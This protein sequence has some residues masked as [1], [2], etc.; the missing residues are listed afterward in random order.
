VTWLFQ[1]PK[2]KEIRILSFSGKEKPKLDQKPV[3]KFFSAGEESP[4][5]PWNRI[6][7][8]PCPN[9]GNDVK[10]SMRRI[11]VSVNQLRICSAF[12]FNCTHFGPDVLH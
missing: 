9:E 3:V 10:Q 11:K 5:N 4:I 12:P 7:D 1:Y 8:S 6:L 2:L